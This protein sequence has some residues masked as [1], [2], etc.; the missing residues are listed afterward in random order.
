MKTFRFYGIELSQTKVVNNIIKVYNQSSIDQKNEDWYKDAFDF[1]FDTAIYHNANE[2]R[3]SKVSIAQVVGMTAAFSP[4]T[5]WERNKY[6]VTEFFN[7]ARV[8]DVE[9]LGCLGLSK[10]KAISIFFISQFYD[11]DKHNQD[12]IKKVLGGNK[13]SAFFDNILNYET[14]ELVTIDRHALSIALGFKLSNEQFKRHSMTKN[15]YQFFSSCYI[16]AAQKVNI[17]PLRMQSITWTTLRIDHKNAL[18]QS[19]NL[20]KLK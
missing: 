17:S 11:R 19:K 13:T 5:S 2:T 6:L 15:Q 9:K 10:N 3:N 18:S 4:L 14:S 20:L 7:L 8:G 16:K 12:L 1:C